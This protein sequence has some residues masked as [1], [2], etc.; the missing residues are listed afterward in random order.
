M[1]KTDISKE[2]LYVKKLLTVV[3][4]HNAKNH[5]LIKISERHSDAFVFVISGSCEYRFDDGVEFSVKGGDVFFL[6]YKS[7]YSMYINSEDYRFIFCDFEFE[8][9]GA[10]GMLFPAESLKNVDIL[11]SRLLNLYRST[12]KIKITECTSVLYSI[13]AALRQ[14]SEHAYVEKG[15]Q[16][17]LSDAKRM[18]DD[19]FAKSD[20]ELSSLSKEME[21]SDVYFR[22]LF[23]NQYG[24]SPLKYLNSLRLQNAIAL[25][26]HP[27]IPLEEC[28][29]QSGFSSLQYFCRVFK[30]ELGISPGQ[31]RK[32]TIRHTSP[33]IYRISEN[34]PLE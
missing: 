6:P 11:F 5:K 27:F 21:I 23:K 1:E 31:F 29:T 12:S 16:I 22:K 4:N 14:A 15:R 24:I 19:G 20:F 3:K 10:K 7:N 33:E 13:Y 28:A 18:M 34:R 25:M 32:K 17:M 2:D 8:K 26:K 9:S 30:K